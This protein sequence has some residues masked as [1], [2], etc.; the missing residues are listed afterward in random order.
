MKEALRESKIYIQIDSVYNGQEALDYLRH[1]DRYGK[2]QR[3][4]LI[5]LDLNMPKMDGREVLAAIKPDPVLRQ[6]PVVILTT[7]SADRDVIQSYDLGANAYVVK[8]V[9]LSQLMTIVTKLEEFWFTIVR[10]P[11][12]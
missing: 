11:C 1:P 12:K 2:A 10:L 4:D 5:L 7:S 6:I 3:P 8:P 9:D